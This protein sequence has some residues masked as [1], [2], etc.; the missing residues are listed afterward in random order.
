MRH[1]RER[2]TETM[3]LAAEPLDER[4]E[5]ILRWAKAIDRRRA[6]DQSARIGALATL[7]ALLKFLVLAVGAPLWVPFALF[8]A[9]THHRRAKRD[10][11]EF[12]TAVSSISR[13]RTPSTGA[14]V[15]VRRPHSERIV[16]FSDLHRCV[17]GRLDWPRRQGTKSLYAE[18]LRRYADDGWTLCENGDVEDFWMVGG[19]TLGATYDAL[20]L[21]GGALG[22]DRLSTALYRQYLAAI[23][24][25]ND[26]IYSV[27]ASRFAAD[28][29][30]LR[31]VGNHDDPLHHHEVARVL[32]DRLGPFP[33]ADFITLDDER[34]TM[35]ALIAHGHHTDGWNAPGR[36]RLGKFST[37]LGNTIIDT[38]GLTLPEGL[39]PAGVA[40]LLRAEGPRDRLI[41][42]HPLIGATTDYDSLD[43]ELL[44][45]SMRRERLLDTWLILGHTHVPMQGPGSRFG[46]RWD[47]YVN[48]GSGIGE[49]LITGIEWDGSLDDPRPVL[50]G[51]TPGGTGQ[52]SPERFEIV[53]TR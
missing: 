4:I 39:P 3:A 53:P 12:P 19:S 44:F 21:L 37:W 49:R 9:N 48:G 51:W 45:A 34:G 29:R 50:V 41:E 6:H 14:D 1:V 36:D 15:V 31:T 46:G 28:G 20:R 30:Y 38:P 16:I 23:I 22:D 2:D 11:R 43:E 33:L 24:D 40:E 10:I 35:T 7:W 8:V 27:I 26:E 52:G 5:S 13:G 18:V 42:L 32:T 25:N 47:R 17:P